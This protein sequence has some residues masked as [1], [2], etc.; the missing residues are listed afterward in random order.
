MLR[1]RQ[2]RV[3]LHYWQG[4]LAVALLLGP[5]SLFF[6]AHP[7][8]EPLLLRDQV[9]SVVRASDRIAHTHWFGWLLTAVAAVLLTRLAAGFVT[10]RRYRLESVPFP[11]NAEQQELVNR[12][13]SGTRVLTNERA[14][15]PVSYGWRKPV[16]LL[17][18][19]CSRMEPHLL[20]PVLTHE[21]L[22]ICRHD[23]LAHVGEELLRA[24]LWFHP[25]VWYAVARI[26]LL[27][28][29]TVD[30]E[31]I[32]RT[33]NA[34]T[35]VTALLEVAC[36][37][38]SAPLLA[39]APFSLQHQLVARVRHI[40]HQLNQENPMTLRKARL[41]LAT[42]FALLAITGGAA[43]VAAPLQ[44]TGEKTYGAADGIQAPKVIF[45]KSPLYP[46]SA[47]SAKTQGVV[48]LGL[49]ISKDGLPYNIHVNEGVDSALDQA[50]I[51]AVQQWRWQPGTKDGEPVL[52]STEINITFTLVD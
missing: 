33:Q 11:L 39:A 51:D 23:W 12:I 34:V 24:T 19:A 22:H 46:A 17:P 31:S 44:T 5:I 9:S 25:A 16:V 48:K 28:E 15:G 35:Y 40:T 52:V 10:L 7:A 8:T 21:L 14:A 3:L 47:K 36:S 6:K 2:P 1:V 45:K 38:G 4:V 41:T 29:Q 27:R 30:L 49:T 20:E 42:L 50:A 18:L 26:R 13:A 43:I 32:A 37:S